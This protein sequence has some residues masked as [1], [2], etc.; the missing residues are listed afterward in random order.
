V[1]CAATF[2]VTLLVASLADARS[3]R[4]AEGK[5]LLKNCGIEQSSGD[6]PA[7]WY[8]C[9]DPARDARF[10]RSIDHYY[11][12]PASLA[13]TD[14]PAD[15]QRVSNNWAQRIEKPP[16]G[17][18]VRL[19]ARVRTEG[20]AATNVCVQAWDGAA[21]SSTMVA[22]ESTPVLRGDNGWTFIESRPLVLPHSTELVVVRAAL[23][24]AGKAWFDDI[25]LVVDDAAGD[26]A[27]V[28]APPGMPAGAASAPDRNTPGLPEQSVPKEVARLVSGRVVR[29]SALVKDATVIAYLPDWAHNHVDWFAICDGGFG[30][31]APVPGGGVRALLEWAPPLEQDLELPERRFWLAIYA[32]RAPAAATGPVLVYPV[33]TPWPETTSWKTQPAYADEPST[34]VHLSPENGW[35]FI[36]VTRAVRA[37]AR[38]PGEFHGVL[39]RF[40]NE[41]HVFPKA[42][43]FEFKSRE[44]EG[45][46]ARRRPLLL[47]VDPLPNAGSGA[48]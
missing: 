15:G 19:T 34:E 8:P 26:G 22:F 11:S 4:A 42:S 38:A 48:R 10:E 40:G 37:S 17:R 27:L 28:S 14:G 39:L 43:T 47:V 23:T 1:R 6:L 32:Q 36:D 41:E 29:A 46:A 5:E 7:E 21:A 20:A 33:L 30:R 16:K 35:K 24:G 9:Y 31:E 44:A 3:V 12:A 2:A 13:I 18:T 25:H 45:D